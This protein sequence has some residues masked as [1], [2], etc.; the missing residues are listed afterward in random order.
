MSNKVIVY[1]DDAEQARQILAPLSSQASAEKTQW[2]LVACAPRMTHRISKWV[3]HSA[4]ENWRTK[5]A[6]KLFSQILPWLHAEGVQASTVLAKGPLP[7]L[8]AQ[9]Q[10][11]HGAVP[12]I[13]ARRPKQEEMA[14]LPAAAASAAPVT[15]VRKP[16]PRRWSLPGTLAGLGAMFMFVAE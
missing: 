5:W 2:V 11:E 3:S 7:E 16:S 1:V 6:D 12:V 4:R 14:A 15:V 10:A 13:D 8:L 9:L